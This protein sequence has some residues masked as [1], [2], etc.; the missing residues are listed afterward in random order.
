[1]TNSGQHRSWTLNVSSWPATAGLAVA[2]VLAPAAVA[3]PA[4]RAQTYTVI[5]NFTGGIDGADPQ[6]GLAMDRAGDFYGTTNGGGAKYL[7][8][9]F[10]LKYHGSAWVLSTLYSFGEVEFDGA[11]PQGR[12]SIGADGTLYGTTITGEK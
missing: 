8:A 6:A 5:H 9:V 4:A 10:K 3:P 12:V 11:D 7:G 1:M 2:I